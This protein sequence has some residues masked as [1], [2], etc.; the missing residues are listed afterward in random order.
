MYF[1][2]GYFS[3][4]YVFSSSPISQTTS[5]RFEL[6]VRLNPLIKQRV[7]RERDSQFV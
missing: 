6:S 4:D 5:F 7:A 2:L 3:P 1:R